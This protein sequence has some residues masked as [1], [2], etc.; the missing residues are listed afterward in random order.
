MLNSQSSGCPLPSNIC[1]ALLFSPTPIPQVPSWHSGGL[2]TYCERFADP[3]RWPTFTSTSQNPKAKSLLQQKNILL[4]RTLELIPP[5]AHRGGH[6]C[7]QANAS[8]SCNFLPGHFTGTGFSKPG[9][10]HL[11]STDIPAR[12]FV[13]RASLH[14]RILGS[15]PGLFPPDARSI[16]QQLMPIPH[17][18]R[19]CQGSHQRQNH[20]GG[21]HCS[22]G[23]PALPASLH[24]EV[25]ITGN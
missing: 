12:P 2:C 8:G 1:E 15:F 13:V 11:D 3:S 25:P 22:M 17:V 6:Q 14:C 16:L 4:W 18:P 10:L 20:P 5:A 21:N 24:R 23:S 9:F 7:A 19:H